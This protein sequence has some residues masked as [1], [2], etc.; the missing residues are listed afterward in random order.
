M[1]QLYYRNLGVRRSDVLM[2]RAFSELKTFYDFLKRTRDY[3][4]GDAAVKRLAWCPGETPG[5]D[6]NGGKHGEGTDSGEWIQLTEPPDRPNEPEATFQAFLDENVRE[7]YEAAPSIE[8]KAMDASSGGRLDFGPQRKIAVIDRDPETFQLL[9]ERAPM[10]PELLIRPNTWPLICQIRALRTL[11]N[12]PSSAHLPLLRLF[13]GLEHASWPPVGPASTEVSGFDVKSER[14]MYG[15]LRYRGIA[16]AS[17]W[18]WTVLSDTD[19]PGTGE[20]RRF[21]ELALGTPDFA[22]LEGPPGSGKTTAICELVLQLAKRGKRVLLS[23]STHVAVDN[24]LERLMDESSPHRDLVIPIRIGDRR[25]VSDG[26]RPW[27]LEHFVETERQRLLRELRRRRSLTRSQ[28][29][30]F[31]AL[32]S[33][34]SAVERLVLDAANLV[35]GT[36]IGILQH[37]DIKSERKSNGHT[38]PGFDVLIVDEASKTPFQEFLVPALLA[39]RWIIVGDPKQ[40]SPY[41]DEHAMAVNVEACLPDARIRDACVDSFM[42]SRPNVRQRRTAAV[43]AEDGLTS[44]AY[45]RQCDARGVALADADC[46]DPDDQGFRTADIVIGTS[47][48]LEGRADAL[49]LD[50]ATV[51]PEPP[52]T[53]ALPKPGHAAH[54]LECRWLV[55]PPGLHPKAVEVTRTPAAL[56]RAIDAGVVRVANPKAK[57]PGMPAAGE[58]KMRDHPAAEESRTKAASRP[59]SG[60][61]AKRTPYEPPV[62][63]EP[64]GRLVVAIRSPEEVPSAR[65]VAA[66]V[67]T[68]AIVVR[69]EPEARSR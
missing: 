18:S 25:N 49:P 8:R 64:D 30:L 60:E 43:V 34:S 5:N 21:V 51:E 16:K 17:D 62:F 45:R 28:Q 67:G 2:R 6:N 1:A 4:E 59:A 47:G 50:V 11:Q 36:T 31:D 15:G 19:R 52:R 56:Q 37:P 41:V 35:C 26:A 53:G 7:V 32:R 39:K 58:P 3:L 44:L 42:A 12:S 65:E 57:E 69:A 9:L 40:L 14:N 61:R 20:Q 63:R 54:E 13:E 29:A 33:G 27:Q 55:Q 66:E 46:D 68:A 38:R 24:V 22:L 10:L 48:A 23:A